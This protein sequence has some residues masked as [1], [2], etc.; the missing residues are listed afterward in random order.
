MFP[1]AVAEWG[2]PDKQEALGSNP[3]IARRD[4]E[5]L[6]LAIGR[7][8]LVDLSVQGQPDLKSGFQESK[9]YTEKSCLGGG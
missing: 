4:S 5:T 9:G 7:Q 2:L 8:R 3:T 1:E 6:A